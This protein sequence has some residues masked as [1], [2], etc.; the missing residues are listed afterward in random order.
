MKKNIEFTIKQLIEAHVKAEDVQRH[1]AE[2]LS[3]RCN[4]AL[5]SEDGFYNIYAKIGFEDAVNYVREAVCLT[6]VQSA[7]DMLAKSNMELCDVNE[8]LSDEIC[9]LMEEYGEKYGLPEGWWEYEATSE[10]ILWKL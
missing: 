8:G 9:D 5:V 10:D 2:L 1:I 7:K 3:R 6:Q 4:F